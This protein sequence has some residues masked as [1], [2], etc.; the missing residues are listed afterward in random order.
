MLVKIELTEVA[1][2]SGTLNCKPFFK[3]YILQIVIH[4]FLLFTI[5][6]TNNF[7][8]KTELYIFNISLFG[9]GWHSVLQH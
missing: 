8:L 7:V 9:L 3:H 5:C 1:E 2:P 6:G 4:V